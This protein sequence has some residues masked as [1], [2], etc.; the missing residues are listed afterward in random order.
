MEVALVSGNRTPTPQEPNLMKQRHRIVPSFLSLAL[1]AGV[2]AGC[3]PGQVG[4][5]AIGS[6][7]EKPSFEEFAAN[8]YRESDHGVF[9]VNGDETIENVKQL[10]EFYDAVYASD[11]ALI[12][13]A[14]GGQQARWNNTQKRNLTYCVSRA[15]F[16]AR[17]QQMVDA[18]NA[19]TGEWEKVADVNFIHVAELDGNCTAAQQGVVF[20]VNQAQGQP[21]LARAFFPNNS[22]GARNVIVDSSSFGQLGRINLVGILRHEL[23][24][25][26]GFR[27]EHTRPEAGTCFEDNRF[28]PL[29]PYDRASVMHYPQCNGFGNSTLAIT[30]LDAQ[31]AAALYGPPSGGGGGGNPPPPPPPPT[32]ETVDITEGTVAFG[33]TIFF[34]PIAVKVGSRLT[35]KMTGTGDADL[36]VRFNRQPTATRFACRPFLDG[37]NETCAIDVP[38]GAVNAHIAV[39][40]FTSAS[41]RLETTFTK[42]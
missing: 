28:Q 11:G 22:R 19:A 7:N 32:G 10:R 37:S 40:G 3:D 13:H 38:G 12:V 35:V 29:T 18:M 5:E 39:D 42:P 27:H 9:V 33:Q 31:G 26:L 1:V 23:G 15:T 6:N 8:T 36:Y 34:E 16:G 30:P 14:P 21:F 24:H 20:D 2:G 4:G 41:F 25:A 17:H